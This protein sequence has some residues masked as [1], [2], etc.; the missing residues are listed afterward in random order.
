MLRLTRKMARE[1]GRKRIPSEG[2]N[3]LKMTR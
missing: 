2:G 3:M 1:W